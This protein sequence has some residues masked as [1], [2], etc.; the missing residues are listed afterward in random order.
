MGWLLDC[1]AIEMVTNGGFDQDSDWDLTISWTIWGRKAHYHWLAPSPNITQW[2]ANANRAKPYWLK[3]DLE[4]GANSR[5][6]LLWAGGYQ[7]TWLTDGH[8]TYLIPAGT[9]WPGVGVTF[10]GW[11]DDSTLDNVSIIDIGATVACS[12]GLIVSETARYEVT[13]RDPPY[14]EVKIADPAHSIN[15]LTLVNTDDW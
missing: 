12:L 5:L 15:V 3:C 13:P 9:P 6:I 11:G 1:D 14:L 4:F 2:L 8:K 7:T 10:Q